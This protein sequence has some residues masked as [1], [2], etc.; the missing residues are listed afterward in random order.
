MKKSINPKDKIAERIKLLMSNKKITQAE[1]AE[2]IGVSRP[3]ISQLIANVNKP[4]FSNFLLLA[5]YFGVSLDYLA[6][7]SDD[8]FI[9][10]RSTED[11]L[12]SRL[13][14]SFLPAYQA[15][16]EKNPDNLQEIIDT[17]S[18]MAEDYYSLTK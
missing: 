16:K 5:E 9:S 10:T 13:P 7:K 6:G 3:S 8:P 4:T 15:A 17:F 2:A 1:L 12:L 14:S 11:I 18:R